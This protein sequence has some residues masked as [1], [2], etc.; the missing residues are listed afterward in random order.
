MNYAIY[1]N[2]STEINLLDYIGGIMREPPN[3]SKAKTSVKTL[4]DDRKKLCRIYEGGCFTGFQDCHSR[5]EGVM[6]TINGNG[7]LKDWMKSQNMQ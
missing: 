5:G 3:P 2:F 1:H 4:K 7:I 6:G